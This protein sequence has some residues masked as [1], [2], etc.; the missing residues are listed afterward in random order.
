MHLYP[1]LITNIII[2]IIII[3]KS[4]IEIVFDN[5]YYWVFFFSPWRCM[6]T[7][8]RMSKVYYTLLISLVLLMYVVKGIMSLMHWQ[9]WA[10]KKPSLTV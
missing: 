4:S 10:I 7:S 6:V 1:F 5:D 8:F 9:R 3:I 2:I